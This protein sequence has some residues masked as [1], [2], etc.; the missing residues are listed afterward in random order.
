MNDLSGRTMQCL[1]THYLY[2]SSFLR[3]TRDI[4]CYGV[5]SSDWL[6]VSIAGTEMEYNAQLRGMHVS[7]PVYNMRAST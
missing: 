3:V 4:C 5:V 2:G 1:R 6:F 7:R